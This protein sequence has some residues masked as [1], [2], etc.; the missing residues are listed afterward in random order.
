MML[1]IIF[2]FFPLGFAEIVKNG[3][4][5]TGEKD[6]WIC[7]GCQGHV[8]GNGHD[9]QQSFYADHR[10]ESWNSPAQFLT[11]A[12]LNGLDSLDVTFQFSLMPDE[13]VSVSWQLMCENENGKHTET[14]YEGSFS[15]NEWKSVAEEITLPDFAQG[16]SKIDLFM[17]GFP[18][19]A[20]WRIDDISIEGEGGTPTTSTEPEPSTTTT[21][22][23]TTATTMPGT[24]CSSVFN[25]ESEE[26]YSWHGLITL[27]VMEDTASIL[28]SHF[29]V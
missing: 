17:E 18:E 22:K 9:S 16:A 23:T 4:F 15:A 11:P 27:M 13:D 29:R 7:R 21:M 28:G 10:T 6:P 24:D 12:E 14:L 26:D 1:R 3:D 19:T 20:A 8:W 5:E 2:F 25:V